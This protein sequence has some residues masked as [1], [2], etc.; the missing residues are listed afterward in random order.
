ME[1]P[2]LLKSLTLLLQKFQ[3]Q[4]VETVYA[5]RSKNP[6]K[7]ALTKEPPT[8]TKGNHRRRHRFGR[9]TT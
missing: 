6:D 7:Y 9:R 4:G 8:S 3:E 2:Q 1:K 5:S